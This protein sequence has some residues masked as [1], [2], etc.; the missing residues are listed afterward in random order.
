MHTAAVRTAINC[1]AMRSSN[2]CAR[3]L[4]GS[5]TAGHRPVVTLIDYTICHLASSSPSTHVLR[6]VGHKFHTNMDIT[7]RYITALTSNKLTSPIPNLNHK[8]TPLV[9]L[10][11]LSSRRRG[12]GRMER[13]RGKR[14]E[15]NVHDIDDRIRSSTCRLEQAASASE[16]STNGEW[17]LRLLKC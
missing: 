9:S 6:L 3:I 10:L 17:L 12:M 5:F 1:F 16:H 13:V 2:Y 4:T 14:S 8:P 7:L 15:G 11:C